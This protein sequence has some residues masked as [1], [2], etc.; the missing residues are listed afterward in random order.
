MSESKGATPARARE[1]ADEGVDRCVELMTSGQWVTGRSH[2]VVAEEFG[3][4]PTTV[5]NWA[6]NA[7]RIIRA[8]VE[9]DLP[10]IRARMIAT[11]D[12]IIAD[13]LGKH[14]TDRDGDVHPSPEGRT[15]VAAIETQAKLL[16]LITQKHE[17]QSL[18]EEQARA[19]YRELTGKDWGA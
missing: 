13:S 18:T 1:D 19:K 16:G 4:S 5:K 2:A 14:V 15:A 8:A 17:V 6:T 7:S 11:L 3:V 10:D 9:G 12:T